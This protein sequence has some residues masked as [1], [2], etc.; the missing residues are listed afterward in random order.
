MFQGFGRRLSWLDDGVIPQ[1]HK[2]SFRKAIEV[3]T[4]EYVIKIMVPT[5]ALGLT[6]RFQH[7]RNGFDDMHV[8]VCISREKCRPFTLL[9]CI[10]L[11]K[12]NDRGEPGYRFVWF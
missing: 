11:Y 3:A 1:G 5:W 7:V 4:T 8:R 9:F 2:M 10:A 12:R 6:K